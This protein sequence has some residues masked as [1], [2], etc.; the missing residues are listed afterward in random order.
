MRNTRDVY[1]VRKKFK[2]GT[3]FFTPKHLVV[4]DFLS[5]AVNE[6][7]IPINGWVNA[8]RPYTVTS[9]NDNTLF[10]KF[11]QKEIALR[12]RKVKNPN[13]DTR[14]LAEMFDLCN[15]GYR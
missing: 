13:Q 6:D 8:I 1:S 5:T 14:I 7:G 15:I 3:R 9:L 10:G 4:I 11:N 12:F 2:N